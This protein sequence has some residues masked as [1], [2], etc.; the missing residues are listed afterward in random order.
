MSVTLTEDALLLDRALSATEYERFER[1]IEQRRSFGYY[2]QIR[3]RDGAGRHLATPG[4]HACLGVIAVLDKHGFPQDFTGK[5]VLDIGCNAGFYSFV[6]KL[7]GARTVLG[8]DI[9]QDYIDQANLMKEI[10]GMDVEFRVSDG[11]ELDASIGQFDVVINTGVI[12]HLQDPMRFLNRMAAITKELMFL[13]S[14]MLLDPEHSEYAW[15]IEK[16]YERDGSNWWIYGPACAERMARAAGFP[17]VKFEGFIWT[18]PAGTTTAEG[19]L[20]QGRGAL[21]CRK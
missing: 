9:Y 2:H 19:F 1:L 16:E 6:A 4:S 10:L 21:T 11:G 20:R 15:F 7:R 8:L 17:R 18:P 5:T 3:I 14:E 13:E 12:Y